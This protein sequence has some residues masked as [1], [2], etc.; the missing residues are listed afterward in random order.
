MLEIPRRLLDPPTTKLAR[1]VLLGVGNAGVALVDRL[2]M[3]GYSQVADLVAVNCDSSSLMQSVAN[4][5]IQ[6]GPKT[7]RGLGAGGDP[8]LAADALEESAEDVAE[9]LQGAALVLLC[10][11]LGG[12]C[13]SGATPL[14]AK[15]AKRTGALVIGVFTLPFSFEGRRR[16]SQAEAAAESLRG[17]LD[18]A[19]I[20]PNDRMSDLVEPLEGIHDTFSSADRVLAECHGSILG[21]AVANGPLRVSISD[22]AAIFRNRTGAALFGCGR[23]KGRNRAQ[24]AVDAALK[25]PLMDRGRLLSE[26][27]SVLVHIEGPE[28]LTLAEIQAMMRNVAKEVE[29]SSQIH[30]STNLLTDVDAPVVLSILATL[31]KRAAPV[32]AVRAEPQ[33]ED[34]ERVRAPQQVAAAAAMESEEPETS[35]GIDE[36]VEPVDEAD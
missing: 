33:R 26:A 14:I 18:A 11:G 15:L 7:A 31:G 23:S 20:F 28:T 12:G 30:L 35:G 3:A 1:P 2:T 16:I 24:E 25:C 8:D 5:R 36:F 32:A 17:L 29:D 13:G 4:N 22:L 27:G 10:A 19:F 34:L 9:A 21:L 6:I